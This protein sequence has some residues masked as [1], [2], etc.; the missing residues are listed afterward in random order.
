MGGPRDA[1]AGR[2]CE[3]RW[4]RRPEEGEREGIAPYEVS[5]GDLRIREAGGVRDPLRRLLRRRLPLLQRPGAFISRTPISFSSEFHHV[6]FHNSV[7]TC[8][9]YSAWSFKESIFLI[10]YD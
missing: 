10:T 1:A 5:G 4:R 2:S 7:E 8:D 3:R 6:N 9:L